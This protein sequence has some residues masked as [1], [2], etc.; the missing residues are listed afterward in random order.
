MPIPVDAEVRQP[1]R[2]RQRRV[3]DRAGQRRLE[4]DGS[5]IGF[6]LDDQLADRR[7]GEP[8]AEEP[9]QERDRR[10][11]DQRERDPADLLERRSTLRRDHD[12]YGNHQERQ[13]ER[14]EQELLRMTQRASAT[15]SAD[16]QDGDPAEGERADGDHLDSPQRDDGIR[17]VGDDDQ[18]LR[19]EPAEYHAEHLDPDGRHVRR[20]DQRPFEPGLQAT[21]RIGEEDV[22]E[23]H[24]REEPERLS[25]RVGHRG[26]AGRE[27]GQKRRESRGDQQR[28]EVALGTAPPRE[29]SAEDVG[30]RDP[31]DETRVDGAPLRSRRQD[32]R[33]RQ[34]GRGQAGEPHRQDDGAARH[35]SDCQRRSRL[36]R[37]N[38]HDSLPSGL[39]ALPCETRPLSATVHELRDS[40]A[41]KE[42]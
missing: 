22:E 36:T 15:P 1:V 21:A 4:V 41:I 7:A 18:V 37:R 32:Q 38:R 17:L 12:P 29:Q 23:E 42:A 2:E 3:P 13:G 8:G 19:P 11:S 27:R 28:P 10:E 39:L 25:D 9:E 30:D 26:R 35:A 20:G 16:E 31:G 33:D 6:E 24:R 40:V 34:A 14:A 5:R